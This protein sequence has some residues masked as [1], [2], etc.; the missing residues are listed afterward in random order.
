MGYYG[1]G[2]QRP[3]TVNETT[4]ASQ[5]FDQ[6]QQAMASDTA[7]FTELYRDYPDRRLASAAVAARRGLSEADG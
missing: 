3:V 6:L 5:I 4:L 1:C 2:G 7:G